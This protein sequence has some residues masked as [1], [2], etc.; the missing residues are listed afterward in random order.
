[1]SDDITPYLSPWFKQHLVQTHFNAEVIGFRRIYLRVTDSHMEA[2]LLDAIAT[3]YADAVK[4]LGHYQLRDDHIW[5]PLTAKMLWAKY[6]LGR[7]QSLRI[8]N[9]LELAGFI[10]CRVFKA[11][12]AKQ[13][14]PP[15][16]HVRVKDRLWQ[17]L[18]AVTERGFYD[19][20][21]EPDD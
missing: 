2:L 19:V 17:A 18:K 12:G 7:R 9:R 11:P 10:E 13:V 1:M 16:V 6:E 4:G 20:R 5:V 21:E 15:L 8:R 3:L 14:G